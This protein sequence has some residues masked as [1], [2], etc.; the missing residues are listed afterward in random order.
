MSTLGIK[1][2]L[3]AD[4]YFND[5]FYDP[6]TSQS[7]AEAW[8]VKSQIMKS[9]CDQVEAQLFRLYSQHLATNIMITI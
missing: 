9:I 1:A 3:S 6:I 5:R 2:V 8:K 7:H 4:N